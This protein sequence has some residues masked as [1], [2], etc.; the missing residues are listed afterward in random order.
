MVGA[1]AGL[2]F[3][4]RLYY[5]QHRRVFKNARRVIVSVSSVNRLLCRF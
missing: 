5:C 1:I 2:D 3:S 4:L